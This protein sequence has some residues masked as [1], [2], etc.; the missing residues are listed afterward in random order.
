MGSGG[1]GMFEGAMRTW[2]T[3]I[4]H[5]EVVRAVKG[6]AIAASGQAL[7]LVAVASAYELVSR[8]V[9]TLASDC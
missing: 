4:H 7:H 9:L 6:I 1:C 2:C 3:Q 8:S 5:M